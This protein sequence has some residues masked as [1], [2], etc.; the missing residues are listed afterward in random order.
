M[1]RVAIDAVAPDFELQDLEGQTVRLTDFR[2]RKNVLIVFN[3]G[4]F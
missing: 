4:L 3:R 1:A 2:D